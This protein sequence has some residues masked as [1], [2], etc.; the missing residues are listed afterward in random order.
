MMYFIEKKPEKPAHMFKRADEYGYF[1][2]LRHPIILSEYNI[3][4]YRN[5]VPPWAALS[6]EERHSFDCLMAHKYKA[7]WYYCQDE[8]YG[9]HYEGNRFIPAA[10]RLEGGTPYSA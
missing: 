1:T 10:V 7:E 6:D 2:D 9:G 8:L 5:N 4:K 3:F